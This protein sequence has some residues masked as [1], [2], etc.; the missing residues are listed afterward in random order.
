MVCLD[1]S[2][3]HTLLDGALP[4]DLARMAER[5][6]AECAACRDAR[7]AAADLRD[8]ATG[9]LAGVAMSPRRMPTFAALQ[10]R[11]ATRPGPAVPES[12]ALPPIPPSALVIRSPHHGRRFAAQAAGV[13][14]TAC[15]GWFAYGRGEAPS[16]ETSGTPAA[17]LAPQT[18]ARTVLSAERV[19]PSVTPAHT[20]RPS[21]DV[22]P[23]RIP[24]FTVARRDGA[25]FAVQIAAVSSAPE[26]VEVP[27]LP[28]VSIQ[29][30]EPGA[31]AGTVRIDAD[32]RLTESSNDEEY[33][34][35]DYDTPALQPAM[36]APMPAALRRVRAI[37]NAIDTL[38]GRSLL[39]RP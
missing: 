27:N 30:L 5:H 13:A 10:V 36:R 34:L 31:S 38:A 23:L 20:D 9:V 18:I 1:V 22:V 19:I 12:A 11:A 24:V 32:F 14:A 25:T 33:L 39:R 29:A 28:P 21:A 3:I 17:V 35:V 2:R 15:L 7:D 4:P 16:I 8:A 6:I 26:P 37:S